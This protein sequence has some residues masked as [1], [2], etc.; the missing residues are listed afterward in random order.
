MKIAVCGSHGTGKSSF[1]KGLA[2]KFGANYIHDI[3]TDEVAPQGFVINDKTLPEVQILLV[4]RQWQ[5]EQTTPESWVADK[6]LFDY[7]VYARDDFEDYISKTIKMFVGSAHYD[8]VFY[9]P[10][11]FPMELNEFRSP[12]LNFQKEMDRRYR[13]FLD[14]SGVKYIVLHDLMKES[15]TKQ[16]AIEKRINLAMSYIA[17]Q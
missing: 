6:C 9:L 3:V 11:E 10:I 4:S 12:D 8:V 15:A 16:E 5:L 14:D 7:L 1:A 13:K 2:E 17:K